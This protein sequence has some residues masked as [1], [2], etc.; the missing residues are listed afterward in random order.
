MVN[1]ESRKPNLDQLTRDGV[2]FARGAAVRVQKSARY[3]LVQP[4][5]IRAVTLAFDH[6]L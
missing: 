6:S 2:L 1:A 4:T 3:A 5:V